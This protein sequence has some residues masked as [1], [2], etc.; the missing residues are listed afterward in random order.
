MSY[1]TYAVTVA[2]ASDADVVTLTTLLNKH[3]G[4]KGWWGHVEQAS[5]QHVHIAMLYKRCV[6]METCAKWWRKTI[7]NLEVGLDGSC[8]ATSGGL[9]VRVWYN[10]VWQAAY[11]N[12][13]HMLS[14]YEEMWDA[15]EFPAKDDKQL[16]RAA[17][18][19]QK[20]VHAGVCEM[21]E[22]Y[23]PQKTP[24]CIGDVR[25]LI[26]YV[27]LGTRELKPINAKHWD[28]GIN[29]IAENC[30][31]ML[32]YIDKGPPM[33]VMK[34]PKALLAAI[35]AHVKWALPS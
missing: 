17:R 19:N 11:M 13:V 18:P 27:T 3:P 10:D 29:S 22:K 26:D 15:I 1:Q 28:K 25:A 7:P 9:K 20:E 6:G 31:K 8:I 23:Y 16:V 5:F 2:P 4:L 24:A 33:P 35:R 30:Y 12:G 34:Q 32:T 14:K 21:W